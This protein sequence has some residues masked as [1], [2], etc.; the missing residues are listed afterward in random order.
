M[1]SEKRIKAE[2][3]NGFQSALI[4]HRESELKANLV[5]WADAPKT[6]RGVLFGKNSL[7]FDERRPYYVIVLETVH[8][9]SRSEIFRGASR[10]DSCAQA[11]QYLESNKVKVG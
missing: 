4:E 7:H 8:G 6:D 3:L 2:L 5:A 1:H 11:L 9:R 10:A